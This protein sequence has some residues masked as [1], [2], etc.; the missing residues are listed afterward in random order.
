MLVKRKRGRKTGVTNA[1]VT[2]KKITAHC[3]SQKYHVIQQNKIVSTCRCTECILYLQYCY[4]YVQLLQQCQTITSQT[5]EMMQHKATERRKN[6]EEKENHTVKFCNPMCRLSSHTVKSTPFIP[7]FV[8]FIRTFA[9][10]SVQT[11]DLGSSESRKKNKTIRV[12]KT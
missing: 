3:L 1:E 5:Q 4:M 7:I 10:L 12:T 2:T 9:F 8:K 11:K 6:S